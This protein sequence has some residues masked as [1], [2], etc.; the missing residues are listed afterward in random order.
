[1]EKATG[2]IPEANYKA[3]KTITEKLKGH[4]IDWVLIGSTNLALQGVDVEVHDID[5]I[6]DQQGGERMAELLKEYITKPF[7]YSEK[8]PF[9]SY[10]SILDIHGIKAEIIAEMQ[11]KLR[12]GEWSDKSRVAEK[13][14]IEYQ[15]LE[16][17]VWDLKKEY[18][19]YNLMGRE[20]KAQ[21][22]K[23]FMDEGI[24]T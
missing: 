18:E 13:K 10:Y 1:M 15:G 16:V 22:I 14:M 2:T 20:E 4:D 12:S 11:Y 7:E 6:T 5:L 19:D 24:K 17:P 23:E 9:R 21:K 3:L 8:G